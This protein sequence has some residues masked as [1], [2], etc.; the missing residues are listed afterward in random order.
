M[1]VTKGTIKASL[2][3]LFEEATLVPPKEMATLLQ[4]LKKAGEEAWSKRERAR[5]TPDSDQSECKHYE[6]RS[7]SGKKHYI[8][9]EAK[10]ASFALYRVCFFSSPGSV[11]YIRAIFIHI[12][13]ILELVYEL[14]PLSNGARPNELSV[15]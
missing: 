5:V 4:Q 13:A 10:A 2:N 9:A 8:I 12:L 11:G 3:L 7:S 6:P 14:H 15:Q 1:K